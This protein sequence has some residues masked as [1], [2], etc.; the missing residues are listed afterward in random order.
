VANGPNIFQMILVPWKQFPRSICVTSSRECCA[1]DVSARMSRG[2]NCSRG[3]PDYL[4][5]YHLGPGFIIPSIYGYKRIPNRG[6]VK[7]WKTR[8]KISVDIRIFLQCTGHSDYTTTNYLTYLASNY[9]EFVPSL[10]T[11]VECDM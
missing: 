1:S 7:V 11:S 2:E 5:F 4:L 9:Q 10:K 3:I 8:R 6:S